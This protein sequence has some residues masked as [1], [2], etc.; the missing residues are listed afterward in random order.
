M[1]VDF[2]G[3]TQCAHHAKTR[4]FE[5]LPESIPEIKNLSHEEFVQRVANV[6][7]LG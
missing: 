6:H 7:D 2:D 5:V 4:T 1:F 3:T